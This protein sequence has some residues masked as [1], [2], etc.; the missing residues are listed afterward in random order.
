MLTCSATVHRLCISY[1]VSYL[2]SWPKLPSSCNPIIYSPSF[3]ICTLYIPGKRSSPS[4]PLPHSSSSLFFF[5]GRARPWG[6]A[7]AWNL[8][9]SLSWGAAWPTKSAS[10]QQ[11][12]RCSNM[13]QSNRKAKCSYRPLVLYHDFFQSVFTL[14][15]GCSTCETRLRKQFRRDGGHI[16]LFSSWTRNAQTLWMHSVR[17]WKASM[18]PWFDRNSSPNLTHNTVPSKELI[19]VKYWSLKFPALCNSLL[20]EFP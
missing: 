6:R 4:I 2:L 11:S 14:Y 10:W 13:N 1:P 15:N 5:V 7:G 19:S 12:D 18:L 17:A 3:E 20:H 9:S 8:S 16:K